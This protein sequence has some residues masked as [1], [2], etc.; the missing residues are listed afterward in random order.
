VSDEAFALLLIDNYL[1]KW[2]TRADEED[3]ARIEPV[4]DG[5]AAITT[6]G[7]NTRGKQTKTAGKFTGKAQGQCRWGG[8]SSEGITQSNFL[9]K[10]AKA[11]R[12][13]VK[14][15]RGRSQTDGFLPDEGRNTKG[16]AG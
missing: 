7:E 2:K 9:R 3:S 10:L 11:D 4:G 14:N 8:W 5:T 15:C 1:E 16:P 6:E 12:E 13:A